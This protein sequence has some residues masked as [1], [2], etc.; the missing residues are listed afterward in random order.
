MCIVLEDF[1][2]VAY[3]RAIQTVSTIFSHLPQEQA[4]LLTVGSTETQEPKC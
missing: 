3:M 4:R 1:I 2:L